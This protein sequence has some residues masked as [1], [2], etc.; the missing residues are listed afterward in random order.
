MSLENIS[1][2]YET[3]NG[4]GATT[5]DILFVSYDGQVH[6][7]SFNLGKETSTIKIT[8][9]TSKYPNI[10][11][12]VPTVTFGGHSTILIDKNGN[13]YNYNETK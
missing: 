10:V 9:N 12:I 8:K 13:K 6:E 2:V 7:I 4:N 3:Y 11:S 5:L 1:S